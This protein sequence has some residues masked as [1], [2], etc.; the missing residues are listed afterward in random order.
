MRDCSDVYRNVKY[1]NKLNFKSIKKALNRTVPSQ[2]E[3]LVH[4]LYLSFI[5][6]TYNIN[7]PWVIVNFAYLASFIQAYPINSAIS[8][9]K[10][11]R[12]RNTLER[13]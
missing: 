2:V 4:V 12:I 8:S 7:L 6:T 13:E 1:A 9:S 3:C 5:E 11:F 10:L